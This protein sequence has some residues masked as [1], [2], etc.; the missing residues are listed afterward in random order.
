MTTY[1]FFT[2]AWT[3]NS[4]V[5]ILSAVAFV[6]YFLAFGQRGRP[7]SFA[8]ALVL[9]LLAFMS[10]FSALANGYLFSAHMVQHIL[11]VL[12]VPALLLLS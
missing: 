6:G 1:Q 12:I 9:F 3:W 8:A 4:I 5:L 7:L 10:P 2:T 11:L